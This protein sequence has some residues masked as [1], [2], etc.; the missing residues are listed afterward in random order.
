MRPSSCDAAE[1]VEDIRVRYRGSRA[2]CFTADANIFGVARDCNE[3]RYGR[4]LWLVCAVKYDE[5]AVAP[6]RVSGRAHA[7]T[8]GG[9][10]YGAGDGDGL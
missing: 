9:D 5:L 3:S 10:L 1:N 4:C 8:K 2:Q 6:A 7:G